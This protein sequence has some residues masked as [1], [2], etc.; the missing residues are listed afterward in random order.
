MEMKFYWLLLGILGVW[1]V[2]S[3]VGTEDGPFDIFAEWRKAAGNGFLAKALSCFYCLSLWV[4]VPFGLLI[5]E[6]WT[7]RFVLWL[8]LS[9]GAILL[10]R[11]T[12]AADAE[13]PAV[14]FE[15]KEN[16][17]AVLRTT[18]D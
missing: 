7:E 2:T 5:G 16:E 11:L 15:D 9:A 17:N 18:E 13:S 4:A 10:H 8:A 6:T 3:L 14:Y 12:Q 1:R